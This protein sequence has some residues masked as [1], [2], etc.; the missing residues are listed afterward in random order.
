[1]GVIRTLVAVVLM[2]GTRAFGDDAAR[3][4]RLEGDLDAMAIVETLA[5]VF[6]QCEEEE[7]Q[8]V[9]LELDVGRSR[10]DVVSKL[11]EVITQTRLRVVAYIASDSREPVGS[12]GVVLGL[13]ADSCAAARGQE[14]V[15]LPPLRE[16]MPEDADWLE[17]RWTLIKQV[18]RKLEQRE[19]SALLAEA[20][21]DPL[22][23]LW[24]VHGARDP[25]RQEEPPAGQRGRTSRLVEE[26]DGRLAL[27]CLSRQLEELRLIDGIGSNAGD[28]ARRFGLKGN[29]RRPL[30]VSSG[31]RESLEDI[32][33]TLGQIDAACEQAD[34]VLSGEESDSGPSRAFGRSLLDEAQQQL[35]R[36]EGL[37]ETYPEILRTLPAGR[38]SVGQT[39]GLIRSAWRSTFQKRQT[40]IQKLR[41][42]L[43]E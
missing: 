1:M 20:L 32:E 42:R 35:D 33:R 3:F 38:T 5:D 4:V 27:V 25:V 13:M 37:T 23:P 15:S 9:L 36:L 8:A 41:D 21:V 39:S 14:V 24:F 18:I 22:D 31:F 12:A 16:L 43:G 29:F 28:V 17:A 30:R 6:E 11:C 2:C 40:A 26:I 34:S 19:A 7:V 10:P